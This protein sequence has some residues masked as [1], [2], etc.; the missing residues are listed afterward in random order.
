[1]S[2]RVVYLDYT[3]GLGIILLLYAHT[4]NIDEHFSGIW[5]SSF[6]MPIFFIVSGIILSKKFREVLP[7]CSDLVNLLKKRLFQLGIPYLFFCLVLTLFYSLLSVVSKSTPNILHYLIRIVSLK[8]IDSLW[9][10]PT[11]FFVELL[12]VSL[13]IPRR[14]GKWLR[15]IALLIGILC[16][17]FSVKS[18]IY[19]INFFVRLFVCFSFAYFGF[20]YSKIQTQNMRIIIFF[21]LLLIGC[22]VLLAFYNGPIGLAVLQFNN[23]WLFILTA[24]LNS[25]GF[26]LLFNYLDT[27]G[28]RLRLLELFGK[29]SIVVLCTNNLLIEIIRIIDSKITDNWLFNSGVLGSIV[30]TIILI[31]LEIGIIYLTRFKFISFLFGKGKKRRA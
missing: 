24:L 23:G 1:M 14:I 21:P 20:L 26:I 2:Q 13:L 30:F 27:K 18:D 4:M 6:F 25:F 5:I 28:V 31:T 3:K 8:G 19:L 9:F 22:G 29:N 12:F 17:G 10:I 16:A 15:I 11:F 7:T